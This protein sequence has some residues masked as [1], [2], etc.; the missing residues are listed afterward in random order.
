MNGSEIETMAEALYH[1]Q[2]YSATLSDALIQ[3]G[4]H[5]QG[6]H[7]LPDDY[8]SESGFACVAP[9]CIRKMIAEHRWA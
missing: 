9:E 3:L 4:H 8:D 6:I 7:Q 2:H 1:E 5:P